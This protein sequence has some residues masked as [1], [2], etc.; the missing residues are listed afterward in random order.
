MAPS[1]VAEITD[2]VTEASDVDFRTHA[3][4]L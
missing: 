4:S 1:F 2:A 3:F